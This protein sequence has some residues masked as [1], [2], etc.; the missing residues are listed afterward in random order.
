VRCLLVLDSVTSTPQWIR[1][2]VG[3]LGEI[4][5][6]NVPSRTC[7]QFEGMGHYCGMCC[8]CHKIFDEK[9]CSALVVSL[10]RRKRRPARMKIFLNYS[11]AKT[12]CGSESDA[13]DERTQTTS[14]STSQE[15][16]LLFGKGGGC[17]QIKHSE[18]GGL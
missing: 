13:N 16:C 2:F 11:A 1:K 4:Y 15:Q 7:W 12:D 14:A 17:I 3:A 9:A 10:M 18:R 5:A 6:I 8:D